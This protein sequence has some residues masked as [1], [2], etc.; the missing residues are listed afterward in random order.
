M[1]QLTHLHACPRSHVV[2]LVVVLLVVM[3]LLVVSLLVVRLLV[4][5]SMSRRMLLLAVFPSVH[6]RKVAHLG[7]HARDALHTF[8]VEVLSYERSKCV[9]RSRVSMH[10]SAHR[11]SAV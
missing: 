8:A 10:V 3:H 7:S 9:H 4:V 6:S 2:P 11:A 5:S 1:N